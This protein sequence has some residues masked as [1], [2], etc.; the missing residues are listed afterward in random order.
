M[1][2]KA[3]ARHIRAAMVAGAVVGIVPVVVVGNRYALVLGAWW[4]GALIGAA[5]GGFSLWIASVALRLARD[6]SRFIQALVAVTVAAASAGVL[7]ATV[8]AL[9]P[10]SSQLHPLAIGGV[11]GFSA[12]GGTL[13]F[14]RCA[15][16]T[17][18][19]REDTT[20]EQTA[21]ETDG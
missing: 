12:L 2:R 10:I 21:E 20:L 14:I 18:D 5:I 19:R 13:F 9:S 17:E 8:W 16:N 15:S 7:G 6:R 3:R 11:G 4:V 1:V